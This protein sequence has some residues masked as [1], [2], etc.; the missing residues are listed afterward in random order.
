MSPAPADECLDQNARHK[1][2]FEAYRSR[3]L[4]TGRGRALSANDQGY[5][6]RLDLS[7]TNGGDRRPGPATSVQK[8]SRR[9]STEM[10]AWSS[11]ELGATSDSR[12]IRR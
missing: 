1:N 12:S 4:L 5:A 10:A 7:Y 8:R 9:R 11:S 2:L 6:D 3:N